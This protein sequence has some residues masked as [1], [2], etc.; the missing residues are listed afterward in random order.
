MFSF[1]EF[2]LQESAAKAFGEFVIVLELLRKTIC[3]I[4]DGP[5]MMQIYNGDI[6]IYMD[7]L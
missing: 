6:W 4:G 5:L 2:A 3:I 1:P 7:F